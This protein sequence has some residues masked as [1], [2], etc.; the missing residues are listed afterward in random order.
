MYEKFEALL[1]ERNVK[2]ADVARATGILKSTLSAWKHKEY[3]PKIDKIQKIADYFDVPIT[4]F[5][6]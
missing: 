1:A 6:E 4:Y 5:L 3:T 2:A